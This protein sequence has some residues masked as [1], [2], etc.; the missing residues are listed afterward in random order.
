MRRVSLCDHAPLALPVL[1]STALPPRAV[2]VIK[3]TFLYVFMQAHDTSSIR[4]LQFAEGCAT[5]V[6]VDVAT[7][8]FAVRRV[9]CSAS[10]TRILMYE[11]LAS[12]LTGSITTYLSLL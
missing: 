3:S 11:L 6:S 2:A 4:L 10:G 5:A 7:S 9:C 1:A 12:D 8:K